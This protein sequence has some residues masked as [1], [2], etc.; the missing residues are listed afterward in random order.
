MI[1]E[2]KAERLLVDNLSHEDSLPL[3]M[4][5]VLV[6]LVGPVLGSASH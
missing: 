3:N 2:T 6:R 4:P 1:R 5:V